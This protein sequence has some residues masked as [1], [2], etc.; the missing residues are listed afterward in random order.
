MTEAASKRGAITMT[1]DAEQIETACRRY[2]EGM[3]S[4]TQHRIRG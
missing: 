1:L 3:F 4:V 2:V